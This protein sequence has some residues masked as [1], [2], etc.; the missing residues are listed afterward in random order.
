MQSARGAP[1]IVGVC[2]SQGSG[3]STLCAE[4]AE[5]FTRA[6]I[7][8]A[9]LSLDDLY[10]SRARRD[11]LG[12][13]VHPLLRTR[14]VPGT[15]DVELG[16]SVLDAFAN[17]RGTVLPRFDKGSDDVAPEAD[18][19]WAAPACRLLLFE[20]WC[21]GA[22]PQG[23]ADLVEPINDLERHEDADGRWRTY[24]NDALKGGYRELFAP[25][26]LSV[27][28]VAPSFD[29]VFAWRRQQERAL[30]EATGS[31]MDDA[32]LARF[33][34]HYERLTRHI[35]AEMPGRADVVIRLDEARRVV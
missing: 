16:L 34:Q 33:V 11:E 9:V 6:G 31:G 22:R 1:L 2:G 26:G 19:G 12:R 5:R 10:L 13:T 28:L 30:R 3:K 15:H 8:T 24:A 21:V 23:D 25:V 7:E 17:G 27:L 32:E 20:G 35:I 14:G 29:I 18:W 4:L